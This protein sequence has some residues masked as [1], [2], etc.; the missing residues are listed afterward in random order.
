MN[1]AII[2][3]NIVEMLLRFI[4]EF[5]EVMRKKYLINIEKVKK[6]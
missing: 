1:V 6:D 2:T 3:L 5:P 4:Y